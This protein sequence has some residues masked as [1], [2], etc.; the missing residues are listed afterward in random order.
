MRKK[1]TKPKPSQPNIAKKRFGMV[2]TRSIE[3]TNRTVS[4]RK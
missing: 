1:E 2:M 3:E 4:Q